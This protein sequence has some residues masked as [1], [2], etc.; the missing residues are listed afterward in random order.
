MLKNQIGWD[1]LESLSS[2]SSV[3]LSN[4]K[5][6]LSL[7]TLPTLI[8]SDF[9]NIS[10]VE[11]ILNSIVN[12]EHTNAQ[13]AGAEAGCCSWYTIFVFEGVM[14]YL[15]DTVPSSL[16]NITSR[17]LRRTNNNNG[18]LCFADRLENIPDGNYDFAVQELQNN[19]WTLQD[20]CP[21]PGKVCTIK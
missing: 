2:S 15:N 18:A 21:K 1:F 3:A 14:I 5:T 19:G 6:E 7:S 13:I 4:N 16:L 17:V 9:N 10:D 11:H 20:W 8:A 12:G